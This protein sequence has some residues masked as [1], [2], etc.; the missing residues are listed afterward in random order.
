MATCVLFLDTET[1]GLPDFKKP[2]DG[3]EQPHIVQLAAGLSEAPI[4]P[5]KKWHPI[6]S[7]DR[8]IRPD[9][10]EMPEEAEAIHGISHA[11]AVQEGIPIQQA[12]N[13]FL[14]L[15]DQCNVLVAHNAAFDRRM[16]RIE[17]LRAGWT[18]DQIEEWEKPIRVIDTMREAGK[19]MRMAPTEAMVAAGRGS[20]NKPPKLT[21]A[22]QFFF[23]KEMEGAHDAMVDV[24]ACAKIFFRLI[25]DGSIV[26]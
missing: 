23:G 4:D 5:R 15:H 8:I 7:M 12:L 10:W 1:T 6:G 24:R 3:P 13:E 16:L 21:E 19:I 25:C 22:Y 2:S 9:G 14:D 20:Q 17:L 26:L 11:R 18:R